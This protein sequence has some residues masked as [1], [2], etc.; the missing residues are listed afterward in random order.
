MECTTMRSTLACGGRGP[1]LGES[2]RLAFAYQPP[3]QAGRRAAGSGLRVAMAVAVLRYLDV[4]PGN[5]VTDLAQADAQ[6][7]CG[8]R[9]V[10][11]R[12]AQG[13]H[14]Y[15]PFLLV[16][17]GLQIVGQGHAFADAGPTR[18]R[19]RLSGLRDGWCGRYGLR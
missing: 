11:T 19:V 6:A 2:M 9:A 18:G 16:E 10:E 7:G 3:C 5:P 13:A 8:G 15:F 4:Q 14:E 12:L 17:P 1:W